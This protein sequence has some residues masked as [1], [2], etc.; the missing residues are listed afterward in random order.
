MPLSTYSWKFIIFDTDKHWHVANISAVQ[1][2][3]S[4]AHIHNKFREENDPPV[5]ERNAT[6]QGNTDALMRA[7]AVKKESGPLKKKSMLLPAKSQVWKW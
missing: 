6:L 5:P 7:R 3:N 4:C 1:K 2:A